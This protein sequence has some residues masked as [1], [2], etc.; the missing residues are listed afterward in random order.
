MNI[1]IFFFL[2]NQGVKT[3]IKFK[4]KFKKEN[5]KIFFLIFII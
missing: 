2:I 3:L 4:I 5:I 1:L